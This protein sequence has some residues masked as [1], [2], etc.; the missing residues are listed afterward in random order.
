MFVG[1]PDGSACGTV[2]SVRLFF[3]STNTNSFETHY[4]WSNPTS[5]TI[6]TGGTITSVTLTAP[7][8]GAGWS[9]FYG[10]FGD[11]APYS[12]GFAA[13][14]QNIKTIGLSFGSGCFFANGVGVDSATGVATFQLLEYK[15]T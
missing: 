15:I 7:L 12:T 8:N 13:A 10:H 9:D 14:I 1:N 11:V 3:Q 5:Y 6:T 4:W 2:N